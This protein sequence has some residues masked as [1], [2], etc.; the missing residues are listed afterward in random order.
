MNDTEKNLLAAFQ[1]YQPT[2]FVEIY[3]IYYDPTTNECTRTSTELYDAPHITVDKD[4][5]N[6]FIAT[7]YNIVNGAI[8][9]KEFIFKHTHSLIKDTNGIHKTIKN[10]SMFLVDDTYTGTTDTWALKQ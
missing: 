1:N 3:R 10:R 9:K 6:N 7:Q 2:E 5:Y 8:V 4:T